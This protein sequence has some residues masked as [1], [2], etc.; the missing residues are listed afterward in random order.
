MNQESSNNK[1][2]AII[3]LILVLII[4]GGLIYLFFINKEAPPL[5]EEAVVEEIVIVQEFTY[6]SSYGFSLTFPETWENYQ[7]KSETEDSLA[8]GFPEQE[9]LLTIT[10]FSPAQWEIIKATDDMPRPN[11]LGENDNYVF[12]W[13]PAMEAFTSFTEERM[14]EI[15]SIVQTFALN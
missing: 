13:H 2:L 10:I 4:A 9:Y 5:V 7:V 6:E 12:A 11:Y 8:F 15:D 1:W 3:F 14:T